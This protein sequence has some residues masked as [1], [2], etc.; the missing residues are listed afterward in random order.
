MHKIKND[1]LLIVVMKLDLAKAYDKV[2]WIFL[3]LLLIQLGMILQ[4]IEWILGCLSLTSF[5]ILINGSPSSFFN[6]SRGVHQECCSHPIR[7]LVS[8]S[9]LLTHPVGSCRV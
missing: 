7:H 9:R 5:A 3:R 8:K 2:N 6:T 4:T 1:K